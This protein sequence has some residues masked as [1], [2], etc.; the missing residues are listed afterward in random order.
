MPLAIGSAFPRNR[1]YSPSFLPP[2]KTTSCYFPAILSLS[3]RCLLA[4]F[5]LSSRR[6]HADNYGIFT[7][8]IR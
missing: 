3:S 4:V 6:P 7:V 5:S 2:R 1:K 8:D